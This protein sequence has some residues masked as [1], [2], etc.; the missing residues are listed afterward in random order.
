MK[1]YL[2]VVVS[3]AVS[4]ALWL[5]GTG[6]H[7]YPG[8]VALAPLPVLLIASRVPRR[9]AFAAALVSWLAGA[10]P[11]AVY[12]SRTLE[13]PPLPTILLLGGTALTYAALITVTGTLIRRGRAGAALL[14]LPAGWALMEFLFSA[15]GLFGAWWSLAYTQTEVLPLIQIAAVTGRLGICFLILLIPAAVTVLIDDR[16]P[17]QQRIRCAVGVCAV[18]VAVAGY[19][20]WRLSAPAGPD[21]VPIALVAVAQPDDFVPVDTPEGHDMIIR[22]VAEVERVADHGARVVVLP[23]KSWRADEA[24]LPVLAGPLTDVALRR[25][26]HIV[27][28]LVLSRGETS[29]NAAIDFPSGL[30]YAKQHLVAGWEAELVP[31]TRLAPVPGTDWAM[32]VCFDLD[33][34]DLVRANRNQGAS[35]LLVPALDFRDDHWMH[36]RMAVLRGV[37]SG[38]GVARVAQL[39]DLVLSDANGRIRAT[40]PADFTRTASVLATVTQPADPTPYARFGEW[41]AV[42]IGLMFAFTVL[43]TV[44]TRGG[45][46]NHERAS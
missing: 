26:V 16:V 31:G 27:A 45:D 1:T 39:G 42:L 4:A 23:E 38:V 41:F 28:G 44:R 43:T 8:I 20:S 29:V 5:F 33:F 6:L 14:T 11:F 37:E 10:I 17:R 35:L 30:V 19:G 24:T 32:A 9:I 21:S 36:S 12:F 3:V 25:D 18:G 22:V 7:P 34:P 40:A 46:D 13:Q 15:T 2:P